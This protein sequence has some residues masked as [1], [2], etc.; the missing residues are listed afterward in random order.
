VS[1]VS[2][3]CSEQAGVFKPHRAGVTLLEMLLVL[4]LLSVLL[5]IAVPQYSE[6]VF[7]GRRK[8]ATSALLVI[9]GRQEEFLLYHRRYATSLVELG[10]S[11]AQR[12]GLGPGGQ[13]VERDALYEISL[14]PML[15]PY[16]FRVW[17]RPVGQQAGDLRCGSY[18]LDA[19]G[20]YANSGHADSNACW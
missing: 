2:I 11:T 10:F 5:V 15:D 1:R 12:V 9:A 3:R 16:Q 6:Q 19:A 8:V 14:E 4:V 20:V 7:R 13:E 17:A 18:S